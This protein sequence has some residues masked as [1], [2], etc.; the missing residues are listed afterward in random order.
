MSDINAAIDVLSAALADLRDRFV[1]AGKIGKH[2]VSSLSLFSDGTGRLKADSMEPIGPLSFG[3]LRQPLA[4]AFAAAEAYLD[5]P[6]FRP[7]QLVV[8]RDHPQDG[9]GTVVS[10]LCSNA[11]WRAEVMFGPSTLHSPANIYVLLPAGW[12]DPPLPPMSHLARLELFTDGPLSAEDIAEARAADA[13]RGAKSA[14]WMRE[15]AAWHLEC[16]ALVNPELAK[17]EARRALA[18]ADEI[19]PKGKR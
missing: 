13:E 18:L 5:A 6:P 2:A 7:G 16:G 1:A 10:C 8:E 3:D 4:E 11:G 14:A 15:M 9:H 19:N 17:D 12:R